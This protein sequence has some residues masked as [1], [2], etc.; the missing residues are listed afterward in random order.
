MWHIFN[1]FLLLPSALFT[2]VFLLTSALFT[3]VFTLI[4]SAMFIGVFMLTSALASSAVI[5]NDHLVIFGSSNKLLTTTRSAA[6]SEHTPMI[7]LD[8][9]SESPPGCQ[10]KQRNEM[11][12]FIATRYIFFITHTLPF[13]VSSVGYIYVLYHFFCGIFGLLS[14]GNI[15]ARVMLFDRLTKF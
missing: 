6:G 11:W 2:G 5:I 15:A 4:T 9:A 13:T 1:L 8:D 10:K 7:P 3:G 14:W 12:L